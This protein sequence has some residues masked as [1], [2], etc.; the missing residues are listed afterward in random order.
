M[1]KI[2]RWYQ[3][4]AVN[5][6]AKDCR[7]STDT[8][9]KYPYI[10]APPGSGK[11]L[12][13]AMLI[14]M[15]IRQGGRVLCLVPKKELVEQ[16]YIEAYGYIE[17]PHTLGIV[18]GQLNKN[19]IHKQ[20]V[21][22]MYSSFLKSRAFAGKFNLLLIDECHMVSNK[23]DTS[24]RKIV[25]SLLTINPSMKI[26]GLSGTPYRYGQGAMENNNIEGEALFTNCAYMIDV[27]RLIAEG[28]LSHIESISGDIEADLTDVEMSGRDYNT[29]QIGVKF[30]AII[31][32]AVIDIKEKIAAYGI[33]TA[34]IFVSNLKNA[35]HVLERWEDNTARI[36]HGESTK[37]ERES[38]VEWIKN[39]NG[40]RCIINVGIYTTGFDY[41]ALDCVVLLRA[42][43]VYSLYKQMVTRAIRAHDDKQKGYIIDY[44]SN[45]ERH[46]PIDESNPPKP[47]KTRAEQPKKL[48]L[49]KLDADIEFEGQLYKR[50]Y[51]CYYDNILSAK[52]CKKCGGKFI[53]GED[54]K[55]SMRSQAEILAEK[56]AN[57]VKEL[58]VNN[59]VYSLVQ[60]KDGE[61]KIERYFAYDMEFVFK[62]YLRLNA[63]GFPKEHSERFL[64]GL[65]KNKSDYYKLGPNGRTSENICKL[66]NNYPQFFNK[67]NKIY[68]KNNGRYTNVVGI[69]YE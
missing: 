19:Q 44:G 18:C 1:K 48:C 33:K 9:F 54:G 40:V 5:N 10:D 37:K 50:G 66:L 8:G 25:S 47:K 65:F 35:R 60:A 58:E 22:A 4:D 23:P 67:P 24:Y 14:D 69:D 30:D 64:L 39:G 31:D 29:D 17:D 11:S 61:W 15:C 57:K 6:A 46:G 52:V 36:V 34:L 53:T 12:M 62:D 63:S 28:Y 56:E 13:Q 16:N 26:I 49:L 42:T 43:A 20:A 32:D 21:I 68:T 7:I 3:I 2:P 59:V 51:D 38:A 41:P 27:K 45:I 55:Y